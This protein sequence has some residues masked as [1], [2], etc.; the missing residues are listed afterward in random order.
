[1]AWI[2]ATVPFAQADLVIDRTSYLESLRALW[3]AE[4]IA[5]WTGLITE[6]QIKESPFFTD[7]AWGTNSGKRGQLIDF[8]I[9]DPWRSDDDTNIEYV[10]VHL[11]HQH[12]TTTLSPQQ[13][14]DGWI[15]HINRKIWVSNKRARTLM[16][17][18]Y[19]P[20]E[21]GQN[22]PNQHSLMIDA[23]LTTEI[24]GA[25]APGL[26]GK[27]LEMADL[28]IRTVA[29]GDAYDAAAYHVVLHSLI[30]RVDDSLPLRDQV[31]W[32]ATEARK[33]IP[34][35]SKTADIFDFV[36]K[37]Y[38]DNPD[39]DDWEATRDR[40]AD[41]YQANAEANGFQYLSHVESSI[42]FA[43]SV[44][45][46]L[47]GEGNYKKTVQ[48]GT[49]SGWDSD[50]PAASIGGVIGQLIGYDALLAEFDGMEFSDRYWAALT[51][52]ALPDYLP[53]D[54]EAD[55]TFTLIAQRMAPIIDI[56]VNEAGGKVLKDRWIIPDRKRL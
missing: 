31:L 11:L 34:D 42:N 32:L 19:L 14:A 6:N 49:L 43:S 52:D 4:C 1:M 51:R 5:N 3:L 46:L 35:G 33:Y 26:P 53:D 45:C 38:L 22:P 20:P 29:E 9:Q 55:D 36:L 48:I 50:N 30:P 54:P 28:P 56:A 18:G 21:T 37:D 15:K 7:E 10:Y 16:D 27:A 44:L 17:E 2:F 12:K 23:Q 8:V 24:F 40:Y 39:K 47:Y 25:Y 41:R 13:I